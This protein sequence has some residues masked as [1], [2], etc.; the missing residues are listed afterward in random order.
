MDSIGL[1]YRIELEIIDAIRL[2]MTMQR[3]PAIR[4]F[5]EIINPTSRVNPE[6]S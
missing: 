4:W 6:R 5:K 2:Q 3:R 1:L